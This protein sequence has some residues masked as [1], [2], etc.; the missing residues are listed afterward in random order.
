[1]TPE[2]IHSIRLHTAARLADEGHPAWVILRVVPLRNTSDWLWLYTLV[3]LNAASAKRKATIAKKL[4]GVPSKTHQRK[5]K[6][7]VKAGQ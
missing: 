5:P 2:E 1:M 6:R 7:S 3:S 4:N